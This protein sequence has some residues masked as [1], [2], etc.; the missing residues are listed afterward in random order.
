[1]K[2]SFDDSFSDSDLDEATIDVEL[3]TTGSGCLSPTTS[4]QIIAR[5]KRR[6]IIEKRRRDRINNSLAELRRLVPTA[7]E[8]Q[9]SSKLE[10]AEILQM[11]VD[12]LKLLQATGGKGFFD[13]HALAMDYR[14]LGFRECLAEVVRFLS[15]MDGP[16]STEA[17]RLRLVSHLNQRACQR[18]AASIGATPLR[19]HP[20]W[21][22]TAA[23]AAAAAAAA[24]FGPAATII[25]MPKSPCRA[26]DASPTV[27]PSQPEAPLPRLAPTASAPH[28]TLPAMSAHA[29]IASLLAA[30]PF[31][32]SLAFPMLSSPP[33]LM[34]QA[35]G[36][37]AKAYRPW[38]A[39]VGAF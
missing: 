35:M 18:E 36:G 17:L 29:R 3:D 25:S 28:A 8:K 2:R 37:S 11:T 21:N 23:A 6:G 10:K 31:P 19:P 7:C 38:G 34:P 33:A 20:C 4:S 27:L 12:H 14:S 16:E 32:T 13:A 24:S 22:I 30:A 26:L 5:K 15:T 1:M 39:E 9:G